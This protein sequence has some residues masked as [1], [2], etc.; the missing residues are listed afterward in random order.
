MTPSKGKNAEKKLT[1][2]LKERATR[3]EFWF[4]RFPDAGVCQ[5]RLPK[6]PA[7]YL[8]VYRGVSAL[9]EVKEEIK[10][11]Q[12]IASRLTQTPKMKRF[13]M[14]GGQAF[15]VIHHYEF[16]VWR[17]LPIRD[18]MQKKG[19]IQLQDYAVYETI[20]ELFNILLPLIEVLHR[21]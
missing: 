3:P 10:P 9:L 16:G 20:K 8:I 14:A 4:H 7:D 1:R 21:R 12:I 6:Q 2:H 5:G 19:T 18:V 11:A 15:F 13:C 17:L